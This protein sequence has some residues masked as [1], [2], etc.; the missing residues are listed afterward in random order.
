MLLPFMFITH[1]IIEQIKLKK[2]LGIFSRQGCP[3][4]CITS[5]LGMFWRF[6]RT[7][8]QQLINIVGISLDVACD[9]FPLSS[10]HA[11]EK[12]LHSNQICIIIDDNYSFSLSSPSWKNEVQSPWSSTG[13]AP[14]WPSLSHTGMFQT[15]QHVPR[16]FP[17]L[18]SRGEKSPPFTPSFSVELHSVSPILDVALLKF[19]NLITVVHTLAL[20]ALPKENSAL[21]CIC[22]PP[23]SGVICELAFCALV[24]VFAKDHIIIEWLRLEES[25]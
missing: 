21:H 25:L 12:N 17:W 1:R 19:I 20:Q 3:H 7:A 9:H 24:L 16:A 14:A 22:H 2:P 5:C 18:L 6:P 11:L 10:H 8:I 15:G 23:R 13:L 4:I